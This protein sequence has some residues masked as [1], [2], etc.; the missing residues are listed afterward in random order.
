MWSCEGSI[1]QNHF[2]S[3]LACKNCWL[4]CED[5]SP[6][7]VTRNTVVTISIQHHVYRDFAI[8]STIFTVYTH[9]QCVVQLV[10]ICKCTNKIVWDLWCVLCCEEDGKK[11]GSA[12][13]WPHKIDWESYDEEGFAGL[14]H[15]PGYHHPSWTHGI[16]V[17]YK[18]MSSTSLSAAALCREPEQLCII[19]S[20]CH[21]SRD[22]DCVYVTV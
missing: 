9:T 20:S 21:V 18:Q 22:T 3:L 4:L 5:C 17:S 6:L 7:M 11:H 1:V 14:F 19:S 8:K 12:N 15:R 10:L 2:N 16:V 13:L